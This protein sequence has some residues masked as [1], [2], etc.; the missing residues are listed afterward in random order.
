MLIF[1]TL[2]KQ[3]SVELLLIK[4]LKFNWNSNMKI[5]KHYFLRFQ[6]QIPNDQNKISTFINFAN[7]CYLAAQFEQGLKN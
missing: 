2:F 3:E 5:L 6:R 1:T 4:E 7:L